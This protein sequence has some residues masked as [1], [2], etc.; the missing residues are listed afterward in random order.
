VL[1][2][3]SGRNGTLKISTIR[4]GLLVVVVIGIIYY[5]GRIYAYIFQKNPILAAD[6]I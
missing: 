3:Y 4:S 2:H 6:L 5:S 1:L